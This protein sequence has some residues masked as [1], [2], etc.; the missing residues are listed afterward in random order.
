MVTSLTSDGTEAAERKVDTS[1]LQHGTY[2]RI[3]Q[4]LWLEIVLSLSII[5]WSSL[6]MVVASEDWRIAEHPPLFKP[7]PPQQLQAS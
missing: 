4:E 7:P 3:L 6:K 5:P 2:L 1:Q